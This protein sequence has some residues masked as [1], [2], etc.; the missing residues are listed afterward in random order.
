MA[1]TGEARILTLMVSRHGAAANA[2]AIC[3][4]DKCSTQKDVSAA[5][6]SALEELCSNFLNSALAGKEKHCLFQLSG[7]V[8]PLPKT[9][10]ATTAVCRF[11]KAMPD[12]S[13]S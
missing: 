10:V 5:A 6:L 7:L 8:P 2:E 3:P 1:R 12:A 4:V 13:L 11:A 9:T